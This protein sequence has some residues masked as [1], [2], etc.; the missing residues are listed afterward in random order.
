MPVM[1]GKEATARIR[2]MESHADVDPATI[3][4]L[5]ANAAL[6]YSDPNFDVVLSK[7]LAREKLSRTLEGVFQ[8]RSDNAPMIA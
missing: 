8:K 3:I 2:E 1:D 7:P 6:A 4:A 5:T